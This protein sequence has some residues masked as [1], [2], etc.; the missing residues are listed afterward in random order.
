MKAMLAERFV[1]SALLVAAIIHLLP[2][3][4]IAGS[5]AIQR[6]YGMTAVDANTLLLLR[7][8]AV[9]FGL[10][11]L[12]LLIAIVQPA[13]RL[14]AMT[15]ALISIVSFLAL[16]AGAQALSPELQRVA[17]VDIVP[18]LL[19][20]PAMLLTWRTLPVLAH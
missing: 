5:E 16:A 9:L 11:A 10:V 17:R 7:H 14:P 1:Q 4:G 19:L 18:L 15:A 3:A 2:V 6:L 20:P 12:P 13:W 8:R